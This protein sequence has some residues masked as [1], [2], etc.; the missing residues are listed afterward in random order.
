[1]SKKSHYNNF[2]I[3][4]VT[5]ALM[6][7]AGHMSY[8]MGGLERPKLLGEEIQTIG[9]KIFF[10][11]GGYLITKSFLSDS[12]IIR[13]SLKRILRIWPPLAVYTCF[14]A[15]ILGPIL[16]ELTVSEY[17]SNR[18]LWLYF[19]NLRFYVTYALPGVFTQNP[20]PNAINGSLWTLPVEVAMY[21]IVPIIITFSKKRKDG[22]LYTALLATFTG[23]VCLI[24]ILHHLYFPSWRFVI[25]GTDIA[26]A[27]ELVPF[28]L[29]GMLYAVT[30]VKKYLNIEV[31]FILVLFCSC[32]KFET[33]GQL[34]ML[35]LV[36]PY[37]IF[38]I[39]LIE[40]PFFG[41]FMN[42]TEISYGIYLYGFFVQQIIVYYFLKYLKVLPSFS[43]CLL[44]SLL[45]TTIL[46]YLSSI[47]IEK[48]SQKLCNYLTKKFVNFSVSKNL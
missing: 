7:M 30:P 5:A 37:I 15:F 20:Y 31:A 3:L 17:F 48:P 12:N 35:Y 42:R 28:Y 46:A 21:I 23:L 24:Q 38:S 26:Q 47:F 41:N 40:K 9:V 34:I 32:M 13:Y 14:A 33:V 45:V 39:A 1:M 43:I 16:S 29:I 25:Y 8:I 44:I 18:N 19:K 36:F 6:V 27:M 10:L 4:R 11:I 2:N 22:S